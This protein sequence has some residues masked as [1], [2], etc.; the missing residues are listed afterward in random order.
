M[1]NDIIISEFYIRTWLKKI[2]AFFYNYAKS[3][4]ITLAIRLETTPKKSEKEREERED[5]K[6]NWHTSF[7]CIVNFGEDGQNGAIFCDHVL[8]KSS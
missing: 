3:S 4:F 8:S 5:R 6:K 7:Y 2:S 1:L